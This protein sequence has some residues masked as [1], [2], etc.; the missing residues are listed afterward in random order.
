MSCEADAAPRKAWGW[1]Y[2]KTSIPY[3]KAEYYI[4]DLEGL[5]AG[6]GP[7]FASYEMSVYAW[8]LVERDDGCGYLAG[9]ARDAA[10]SGLV[11][12]VGL[13]RQ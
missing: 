12:S 11:E 4:T 8:K 9:D 2:R 7:G 6:F 10:S 13:A 3:R 5:R 1:A